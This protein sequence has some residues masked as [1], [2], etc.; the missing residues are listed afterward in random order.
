MTK[1]LL[2]VLL[3][4]M[5]HGGDSAVSDAQILRGLV[6]V[7]PAEE[8]VVDSRLSASGVIVLDRLSGQ[9]VYGK[10]DRIRRPMASITKLMTALVVAENHDLSEIVTIPTAAESVPGNKAYLKAGEKFTVGDLLSALL[11]ASANDAAYALAV[12]HSGSTDDFVAEMN[13]RAL[14]LGLKDTSYANPAGLDD[15]LQ[16]STPRDIAW[17]T[18]HVLGIEP[19]AQRMRRKW[20][21]IDSLEGT[22]ISLSH[23]HELIQSGGGE[24]IAGKTGTTNAAHECLV[25]VFTYEGREYIMVLLHSD[26]RYR[27]TRVL[28]GILKS[29][30][31]SL[32]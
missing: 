23:T 20:D 22:E 19:I 6:I 31:H 11:I 8:M 14:E 1:A 30:H 18:N 15:E 27:D 21:R 17:L 12:Y 9:A 32:V 3:M 5:W 24:V 2:S 29:R 28:L 26:N 13:A 4:G 7:P 16:Y 25:S 10:Q